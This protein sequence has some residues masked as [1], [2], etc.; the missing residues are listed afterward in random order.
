MD[1]LPRSDLFDEEL[2]LHTYPDIALAVRD[3]KFPS[4]YEHWARYGRLELAYSERVAGSTFLLAA[5]GHGIEGSGASD[6]LASD[7]RLGNLTV[8]GT[9]L[10]V[11]ESD[12]SQKQHV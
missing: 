1:E 5:I 11:V 9:S 8:G 7:H 3:R 10:V 6:D 12:S 4:G 2:Y